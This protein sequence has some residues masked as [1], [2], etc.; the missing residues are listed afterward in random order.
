MHGISGGEMGEPNDG[1]VLELWEEEVG[2][3]VKQ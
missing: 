3:D 1:D 2:G